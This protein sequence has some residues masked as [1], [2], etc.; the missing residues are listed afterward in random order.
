[1]LFL[2]FGAVDVAITQ[3]MVETLFVVLI[4]AVLPRLPRFSGVAHPGVAGRTRDATIA[5]AC[6]VVVTATVLL[7][8]TLPLD[9]AIPDFYA[10]ASYD[11][12]YGRNIVNVILVDFR[13]LDTLGEVAVVVAAALAVVALA[14]GGGRRARPA[15][16]T[17]P[18]TVVATPRPTPVA[19]ARR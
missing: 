11:E 18:S 2:S 4:A 9:V 5:I 16:P 3:L 17:P 8:A 1:M 13:A 12:A 19:G 15:V 14:S 10:A 7:V 6:G